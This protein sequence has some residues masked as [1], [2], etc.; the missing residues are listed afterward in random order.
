MAD[1]L[2]YKIVAGGCSLGYVP[3]CKQMPEETLRELAGV[4]V[5]VLDGLRH[6]AH[7]T[8]MTVAESVEILQRIGARRSF[9][10]H[11]CHDLGHEETQRALPPGIEVSWDGLT[12]EW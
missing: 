6:R 10:T 12:L 5:M 4:D 11:M 2:G 9:L 1:T 3:D 7:S 8:H